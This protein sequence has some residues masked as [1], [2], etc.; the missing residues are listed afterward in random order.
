MHYCYLIAFQFFNIFDYVYHSICLN[1]Y[2]SGHYIHLLG[3]CL[4]PYKR[5]QVLIQLVFASN[6]SNRDLLN[7]Y[8]LDV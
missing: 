6:V 2:Y 5:L 4:Q 7:L 1:I 8:H 3:I